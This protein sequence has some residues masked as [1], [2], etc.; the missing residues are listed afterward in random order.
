M[1]QWSG[2]AW[3]AVLCLASSWLQTSCDDHIR[4]DLYHKSDTI[5]E[6]FKKT[7]LKLPTRVRYT[8]AAMPTAPF[9]PRS[10]D[11]D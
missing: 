4:W 6:F 9:P 1:L 7:A 3:V 10:V 11:P 8:S 2:A 5:L